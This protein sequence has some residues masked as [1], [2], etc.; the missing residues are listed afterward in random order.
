[1]VIVTG[2]RGVS[3]FSSLSSTVTTF[4][5][6]SLTG[7]P[8]RLPDSLVAARAGWAG[9]VAGV[10]GYGFSTDT[11]PPATFVADLRE[12]S[13]LVFSARSATGVTHPP[14]TG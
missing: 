13:V 9:D 11:T 2:T 12:S 10:S 8:S 14:V 7:M 5:G 3:E 1:L 4:P 6:V